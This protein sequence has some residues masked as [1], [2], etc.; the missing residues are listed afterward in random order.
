MAQPRSLVEEILPEVADAK[1]AQDTNTDSVLLELTGAPLSQIIGE[2]QRLKDH[3][4]QLQRETEEL[5]RANYKAFIRAAEHSKA[6]FT[7]FE[8]VESN[9]DG[10]LSSLP[11][12]AEACNSLAQEAKAINE[13][14]RTAALMLTHHNHV[15]D[16]LELPQLLDA[17]IKGKYFTQALE[18]R[19]HVQRMTRKL[20]Q[21]AVVQTISEQVSAMTLQ[22][23]SSLVQQLQTDIALA[24]CLSV[25]G[26]LR[27]LHVLKDA[28]LRVLFLQARNAFLEK[29]L[30]LPT[31]DAFHYLN[32]VVEV[33]RRHIFNIVTQYRAVFA[34][35]TGA[36]RNRTTAPVTDVL[37]DWAIYRMSIFAKTLQQHLP[38]LNGRVSSVL[39]QAMHFTLSMGRC[40]LDCRAILVPVFTHAICQ[41]FETRIAQACDNFVKGIPAMKLSSS[42]LAN[43]PTYDPTLDATN[44]AQVP[45]NLTSHLALATL[46][47]NLI[48]ALNELRECAPTEL[49][50]RLAQSL[51][52]QLVKMAQGLADQY[53]GIKATFTHREHVAYKNICSLFATSLVPSIIRCYNAIYSE[54]DIHHDNG[55]AVLDAAQVV[56]LLHDTC[57]D[58]VDSMLRALRPQSARTLLQTDDKGDLSELDAD[59]NTDVNGDD[60]DNVADGAD[61]SSVNEASTPTDARVNEESIPTAAEMENGSEETSSTVQTFAL[62]DDEEDVDSVSADDGAPDNGLAPKS[63]IA[64]REDVVMASRDDARHE[65]QTL[66]STDVS[67]KPARDGEAI[68]ADW[69]ET[70]REQMQHDRLRVLDLF[71]EVDRNSD[72]SVTRAELAQFLEM[73]E[74]PMSRD[75]IKIV[76]KLVDEDKSGKID[77]KEFSHRVYKRR[78]GE[79]R[80]ISTNAN[81]QAEPGSSAASEAVRAPEQQNQE[82]KDNMPTDVQNGQAEASATPLDTASSAPSTMTKAERAEQVFADWL[83]AMRQKMQHD[84]LRVLDLFRQCD[85]NGDGQV[86]RKE[87]SDFLAGCDYPMSRSDIKIVMDHIDA[88]HSGKID[89]K[90]FSQRVHRKRYGSANAPATRSA[91]SSSSKTTSGDRAQLGKGVYDKWVKSMHEQCSL[92]QRQALLEAFKGKDAEDTGAVTRQ[93][94]RTLFRKHSPVTLNSRELNQLVTYL[95]AD[96]TMRVVYTDLP[97]WQ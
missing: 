16:V 17:C 79:K 50:T 22:M 42:I 31:T 37:A 57:P 92:E 1:W 51:Q 30:Q 24:D 96:N 55:K 40:G 7:K 65:A 64:S 83:E 21:V 73:C 34:T 85:Q 88:D 39:S 35:A 19:A 62:D 44:T 12:L 93:S 43:V 49:R 69:L 48:F 82:S 66:N 90:E 10:L 4:S 97:V 36:L 5:A 3:Q 46:T 6:I 94:F 76:M 71:R 67:V 29:E 26:H 63:P 84:H 20:P 95:D 38:R 74:H 72:G 11:Q 68:F 58:V 86:T 53:T 2:N 13:R 28:E 23:Q 25:V 81:E 59:K 75:D 41:Q 18:L 54:H 8:S 60:D 78:F 47:N 33:S 80:Q 77:Y 14:R 56:E 70:M 9:A 52:Q 32:Q 91:S 87:L 61:D 89:Y 15:M 45:L 27:T